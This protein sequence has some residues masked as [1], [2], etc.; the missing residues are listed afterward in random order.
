MYR[1]CQDN[2]IH[3]KACACFC[4]IDKNP[5]KCSGGVGEAGAVRSHGGKG[6]VCTNPYSAFQL[7][8]HWAVFLQE[9]PQDIC[10]QVS[11]LM[12][13]PEDRRVCQLNVN[14]HVF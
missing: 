6:A 11:Y 5:L 10:V 8:R 7:R 2:Q 13:H 3:S 9:S 4:P 14:L 12:L 1:K